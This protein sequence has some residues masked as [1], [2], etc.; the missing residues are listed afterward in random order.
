MFYFFT[1][2]GFIENIFLFFFNNLLK[3]ILFNV[4][5]FYKNLLLNLHNTCATALSASL[6]VY[7]SPKEIKTYQ[8]TLFPVILKASKHFLFYDHPPFYEQ[9]EN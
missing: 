5:S 9:S 8:R 7:S 3:S 2:F 1:V 6:P 4:T